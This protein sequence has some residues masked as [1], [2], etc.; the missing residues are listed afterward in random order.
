MPI[1]TNIRMTMFRFSTVQRMICGQGI[2]FEI[3][4]NSAH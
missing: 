3:V 4:L 2:T 1:K